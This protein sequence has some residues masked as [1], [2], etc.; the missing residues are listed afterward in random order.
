MILF[1]FLML[2]FGNSKSQTVSGGLEDY[3]NTYIANLPGSSGNQYIQ[4]ITSQLNDWTTAVNEILNQNISA[5]QTTASTFNYQVIEYTDTVNLPGQLYYILEEK[6]P[7]TNYWGVYV[8]NAS[9]CRENLILQAPHPKFDSNTGKQAVYCFTRLNAKALFIS[10][11]HRCN[12]SSFSSCDGTTTVCSET[13]SAYPIS[14]MA[15]NT[16][17]A[18][19]KTTA[20]LL[21]ANSNAVF[22]QLHGFGKKSTDPYV[23]M[24]NGTRVTPTIDYSTQIQNELSLTDNSLTFKVAHIDLSWTR[25]IGFTNTQGRLINSSSSVC[26]TDAS[27]SNGGFVHIEQEKNKL[28]LDSIGWEKVNTSLSNVFSCNVLTI[29]EQNITQ[30]GFKV[31]PNPVNATQIII[32]ANQISR[33]SLLDLNGRTIINKDYRQKSTVKLDVTWLS[34]GMYFLVIESGNATFNQKVIVN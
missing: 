6:S 26:D 5:A 18:F 9:P 16:D 4:A 1:L 15:H 27:N 20:A 11:T 10:G 32:E 3:L 28:R 23:I 19:Q 29:T 24:S 17:T 7:Q 33:V 22:I 14:D 2:T 34:S 25:L 21:S 8:F 30:K 31:Y 13:S 12:H